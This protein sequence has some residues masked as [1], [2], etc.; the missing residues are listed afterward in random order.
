MDDL[1]REKVPVKCGRCGHVWKAKA[2]HVKWAD[3]GRYALLCG[4][5]EK[6]RAA[7]KHMDAA[8]RLIAQADAIHAKRKTKRQQTKA[9]P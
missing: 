8:R 9:A 2:Y 4:A 1:V 5:C 3:E 6:R 7:E